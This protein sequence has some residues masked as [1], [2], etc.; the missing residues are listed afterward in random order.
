MTKKKVKSKWQESNNI[1]RDLSKIYI[2]KR[3][4][5]LLMPV[6]YKWHLDV[7]KIAEFKINK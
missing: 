2:Y 6:P 3:K 5:I 1:A 4:Q 7:K